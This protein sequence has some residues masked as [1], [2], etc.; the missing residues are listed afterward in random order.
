MLLIAIY[1]TV[2][3]LSFLTPA[4]LTEI[5]KACLDHPWALS[6]PPMGS[7]S[8]SFLFRY[9]SSKTTSLNSFSSAQI[10][11]RASSPHRRK[12]SV[13]FSPLHSYLENCYSSC[14][15]QLESLGKFH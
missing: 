10:I 7:D 9:P 14:K 5:S 11:P 4:D 3:F 1:I 13:L 8:L 2:S 12:P 6:G 15:T